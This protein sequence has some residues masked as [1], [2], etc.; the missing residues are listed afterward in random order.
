MDLV[1]WLMLYKAPQVGIRTFYRVLKVFGSPEQVFAASGAQLEACGLFKT[2]TLKY[3]LSANP[4]NVQSDLDWTTAD[5]CYILRLIDE[6]YPKSL[7]AIYDPPPLLYVRGDLSCLSENQLGIVG[8]RHPTPGG[9]DHAYR[10][11]FELAQQGLVITSG[12]ASGIDAQAHIGALES[13]GKT[14]A[15]CGTGLDRVYPAKHRSLAKQI[16]TQG[17]LVSEF[18]LG[19][20]PLA[21]NFPRRNRLIG[22]L[23]LGV[24]VVEAGIKSGTMI[25][26]KLAAEQGKEV[27]AIP[28]SIHNPLAQGPHQ[29]IKDGAKLS[30]NIGDIFDE[31]PIDFSPNT[32]QGDDNKDTKTVDNN[33]TLLLKYLGYNAVTVDEMVEKSGLSPQIVTQELLLLELSKQ[34][35]KTAFGYVLTRR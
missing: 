6:D 2:Q 35:E 32:K 20:A 13:G 5:D 21:A 24:L 9:K 1:Y 19:T 17:A 34:V 3:L 23:S 18:M 11:A 28:S 29:L 25:T 12:M 4:A 15:I 22:A 10:F 33:N 14:I 31:L 26:A 8:S 27:F 16:A 30:E 7:A